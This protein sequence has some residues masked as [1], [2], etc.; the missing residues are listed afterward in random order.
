MKAISKNM[1]VASAKEY[2][3]FELQNAIG[4]MDMVK[5]MRIAAKY[6][7]ANPV[8]PHLDA[9]SRL[10]IIIFQNEPAFRHQGWGE[11]NGR[12]IGCAPV[13]SQ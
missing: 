13:F 7:T 4:Q 1:L 9:P 5:V 6:F 11:G 10:Y 2:N 3:V 12:R 8:T